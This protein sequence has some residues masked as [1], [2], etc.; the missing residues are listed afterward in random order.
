[1]C[2]VAA[3]N[4]TPTVGQNVTLTASCNGAPTSYAWTNCASTSSTCTTTAAAAGPVTYSVA[5]INS[6]GT[7]TAVP[8]TV[9]WT[10]NPP[11]CSVSTSNSTPSA[12]QNITL[13]ASCSGAPTSYVWTNC[14]SQSS[15]CITTQASAGTATYTVAAVNAFGTSNVASVGVNWQPP[16]S[17]GQDFCGSYSNVVRFTANW[18][19]SKR[20]LTVSMGGFA[21]NGVIVMQFTVPSSPASYATAGVT[22]MAEYAEPATTRQMTLSKSSCDFRAT[23]SSGNNGPFAV[24]NGNQVGLSF[25]VGAQPGGLVPGQTYYMNF[26]N[27]STDLNAISCSS[28]TCN[29]GIITIPWPH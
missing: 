13:T 22:N 15:T 9:T 25:N 2:T 20:F 26:R 14:S 1:V 21:S 12:G 5:G 16:N 27:W 8:V 4:S 23:D 17:S 7:G 6:F 11:V 19:D 18:G 24:T 10:A 29:A 28:N 3:S